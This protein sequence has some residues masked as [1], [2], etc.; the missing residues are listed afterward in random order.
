MSK[1]IYSSNQVK[2]KAM[3]VVHLIPHILII[4]FVSVLEI[5]SNPTQIG[6]RKDFYSRIMLE[7][8]IKATAIV[9]INVNFSQNPIGQLGYRM[10]KL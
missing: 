2:R 6:I 10:V 7:F 4:I 9:P 1:V 5:H 8:S 3:L